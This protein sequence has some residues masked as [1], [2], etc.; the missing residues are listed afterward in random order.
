MTSPPNISFP[1]EKKASLMNLKNEK[2]IIILEAYL[3]NTT[4]V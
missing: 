2:D 4:V 3:G 1:G